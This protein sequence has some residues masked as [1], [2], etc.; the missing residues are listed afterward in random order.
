MLTVTTIYGK[1]TGVSENGCSVFKGVPY[2]AP[3]VK[4]L[5]FKE[6]QKPE[7]FEGVYA[8]DHFQARC[9]QS[10]PEGFYEKEFYH[11]PAFLPEMSEDC[12]YLNIWTPAESPEEK[13]PVAFWIHGGA[14]MGGFGS[15]AEFDGAAFARKGVILVTINYRLNI[16]GFFAH[17][18]LSAESPN[19]VSGNYGILDQIAALRWVQENIAEF[20]GDPEKVTVFGQS[21]GCMSIQ[22][23]LSSKLSKGLFRSAILQS[24]AGYKR[25]F[26]SD[27]LLSDGEKQGE[28][29]CG[30]FGISSLLELREL[31][32]EKLYEMSGTYNQTLMA[33]FALEMQ[34]KAAHGEEIDISQIP[35]PAAPLID[36]YLMKKGYDAVLENGDFPDLPYII[37]CCKDDLGAGKGDEDNALFKGVQNLAKLVHDQGHQDAYVYR[38]DREMPGDEAGAFHSSELWY[39]FGSYNRCWRDLTEADAGLSERIVSYWTNF[40]KTGDPNGESL[41]VWKAFK[42]TSEEVLHLNI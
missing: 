13:L 35:L 28:E 1:I 38:F 9:I 37:G 31:P 15:E 8:A 21:A 25:G 36:G 29:F 20:G 22:T 18:W 40:V 11:D 6:P 14:Y 7:P 16:F 39:V 42:G 24:A 19:G 30:M 4:D 3:P 41:P 5:R 27:K 34:E 12:L 33:K 2:A 23:L 10:K 26:C 32:A 17:P